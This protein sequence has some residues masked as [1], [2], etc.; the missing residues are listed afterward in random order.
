ML[1][2]LIVLVAVIAF[3][4]AL[5]EYGRRVETAAR[6]FYL[7]EKT[8]LAADSFVKNHSAKNALLGA[9]VFD[10]EKMRVKSNELSSLNFSGIA[11]VDAGGFFVKRVSAG[12]EIIYES[13][14]EGKNCVSVKRFVL[15]DS[16]KKIIFYTGCLRE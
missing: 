3:V 2:F 5:S 15:L 7:E 10:G 14:E 12:E 11:G 13:E 1:A 9:A 16:A 4:S 8:M 6:N